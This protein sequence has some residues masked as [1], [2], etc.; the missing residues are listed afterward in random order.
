MGKEPTTI[1]PL[2]HEHDTHREAQQ[3]WT[4]NTPQ[5]IGN[6]LLLF[7]FL[8]TTPFKNVPI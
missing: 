1:T 2:S 4:Y 7:F 5:K 6:F 3:P 8:Q